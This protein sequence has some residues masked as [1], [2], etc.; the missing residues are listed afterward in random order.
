[1]RGEVVSVVRERRPHELVPFT[2][3]TA[4][5]IHDVLPAGEIM[6]GIVSDA[7]E[8]LRRTSQFLQ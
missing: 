3:R 2:G 8:A 6:R 1:M 5:M 4:G 7:E